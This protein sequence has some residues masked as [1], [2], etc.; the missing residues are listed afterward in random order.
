MFHFSPFTDQEQNSPLKNPSLY[1][2]K[3]SQT[4]SRPSPDP[5]R[6]RN[7]H[8]K[9][10]NHGVRITDT[11]PASTGNSNPAFD[12]SE[13]RIYLNGGKPETRDVSRDYDV[14][15]DD[16]LTPDGAAVDPGTFYMSERGMW[17]GRWEFLFSSISFV[18]GL[19][20]I[21]RFP[22]LC[23]KN[24]GGKFSR[25]LF[26]RSF[27]PIWCIRVCVDNANRALAF[28]LLSAE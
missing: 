16:M 9:R 5:S 28:C 13:G 4:S 27:G 22:Y 8:R 15:D 17:S 14:T 18:I 3:S 26:L 23:Y 12:Q 25:F 1:S 11:A 10:K 21:W 20:N 19:G 24:G 6:F 2:S 7:R